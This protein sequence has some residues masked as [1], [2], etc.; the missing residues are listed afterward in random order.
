MGVS[1]GPYIV[2]DSSLVLELDA[3]DRNSYVSGSTTWRDLTANSF[4]G[5]LI[6]DPTF[7]S[8]SGGSIMFDG[9]NDSVN[10]GN[11]NSLNITGSLT[12]SSWIRMTSW[13]NYP[14]VISK[15]YDTTGGYSVHIRDNYSIWFEIYS[16]TDVRQQ[17]NPTNLTI[18]LNSWFNVVCTYDQ[19][20]MQVYINGKVVG[21]GKLVSGLIKSTSS[22][23]IIGNLPSYGFFNGLISN[24]Q[25]YNRDLSP[26][27]ILQNYNA[28]KSRFNL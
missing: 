28:L 24:T 7:S 25:I 11:P 17:Y 2:R 5:S 12:L 26:Q 8:S 23:V 16:S 19:T 1:G 4:T 6:N 18:S 13:N 20:Q 3:A 14:G 10:L 21:D 22:N 27:E 15:G 9:T